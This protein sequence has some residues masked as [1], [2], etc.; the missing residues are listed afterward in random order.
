MHQGFGPINT[1]TGAGAAPTS[2]AGART[3]ETHER[4]PHYTLTL[5]GAACVAGE[6]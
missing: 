3:A 2:L 1:P 4:T 5:A 6:R